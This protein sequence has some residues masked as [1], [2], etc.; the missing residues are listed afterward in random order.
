[1]P[2]SDVEFNST[3]NE[4]QLQPLSGVDFPEGGTEAMKTVLG[5]FL[6]LFVQFGVMNSFGVFESRYVT[7]C[8]HSEI[9]TIIFED[10]SQWN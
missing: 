5:A 10:T 7:R 1:M 6:I 9:G 2:V 3:D 4:K 8:F